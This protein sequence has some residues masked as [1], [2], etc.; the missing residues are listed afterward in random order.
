MPLYVMTLQNETQRLTDKGEHDKEGECH[1]HLTCCITPC[2]VSAASETEARQIMYD[3]YQAY[4]TGERAAE[5]YVN[6]ADRDAWLSSELTK[7]LLLEETQKPQILVES[8]L[9]FG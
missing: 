7:C 9:Y 6:E 5:G 3:D 2:I 1:G 4:M 8:H